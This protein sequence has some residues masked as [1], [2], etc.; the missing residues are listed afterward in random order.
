MNFY[1]QYTATASAASVINN[2]PEGHRAEVDAR[3]RHK[4]SHVGTM[5]FF[6]LAMV[7]NSAVTVRTD[8]L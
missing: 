5:H 6:R 7:R 2:L 1:W 8:V 4:F 3:G